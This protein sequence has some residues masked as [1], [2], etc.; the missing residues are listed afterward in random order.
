MPGGRRRLRFHLFGQGQQVA[1]FLVGDGDLAVGEDRGHVVQRETVLAHLGHV[2][3][4]LCLIA[5]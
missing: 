3:Q 5:G 4:P 1:A 2:V